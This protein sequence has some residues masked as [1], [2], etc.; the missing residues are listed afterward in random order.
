MQHITP[1]LLDALKFTKSLHQVDLP[2]MVNYQR[3]QIQ[4]TNLPNIQYCVY[5][6]GNWVFGHEN[7]FIINI[8]CMLSAHIIM[9]YNIL[10]I[11]RTAA[12]KVRDTLI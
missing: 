5:V 2:Q 10:H 12:F 11:F 7:I 1:R 8:S 6:N 4:L 9:I 3:R